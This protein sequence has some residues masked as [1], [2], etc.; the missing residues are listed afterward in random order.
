M[1]LIVRSFY[2]LFSHYF[3]TLGLMKDQRYD[4][5]IS[6][7]VFILHSFLLFPERENAGNILHV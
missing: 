1:M 7:L 2:S 4:E 5:Y 6:S 3:K